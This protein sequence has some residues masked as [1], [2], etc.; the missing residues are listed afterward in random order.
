MKGARGKGAWPPFRGNHVRG[1]FRRRVPGQLVIQLTDR[2]NGSCPQCGMRVSRH[3]PRST[4]KTDEVKRII[5]AAVA[6]GV[7]ILSFTGGE[8]L[9][10]LD[11]LV[12]LIRYAGQ[13]GVEY[14]RTGTNGFMFQHPER[15]EFTSRVAHLADA[16][17]ATPLRNFWI[18][19][20]SADPSRHEGMRG[21]AGVFKGIEKALPMFHERGLYPT[22]NLGINRNLADNGARSPDLGDPGGNG[23]SPHRFY[24]FYRQAFDNFYRVVTEMG[25]TLVSACY[26][27]SLVQEDGDRGLRAVYGANS[28]DAVVRFSR[29][30]KAI[31]FQGLLDTIPRHRSRIRIVS[32]RSA[33]YALGR[34]QMGEPHVSYPCL[35]GRDYFFVNA[36]DGSTYPCGYR[37]GE[38]LGR[39]WSL[40]GL[41]GEGE[42]NC[43]RCEWECFRDPSYLLHPFLE[44]ASSPFKLA[45]DLY[46][47]PAFFKL[48]AEDVRYYK[49]CDLFDGRVPP[50]FSRLG[51]F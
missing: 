48:W 2:C 44:A 13:S 21:F 11:E 25:F 8:P 45:K 17:A 10:M 37:G 15:P 30:E 41:S 51:R 32:P 43:S 49:T 7:Q 31:L 19:V 35:G 18:S 38:N 40:D 20:D 28:P 47:D 39:L 9:L 26:P 5:D 1:F 36:G 22:A 33:L 46:K 4:L 42:A 34:A 24:R 27:I 6:R 3:F 29:L 16:L 14:I 23:C 12:G 50:D